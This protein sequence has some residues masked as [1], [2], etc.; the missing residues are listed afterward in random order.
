MS[1]PLAQF[2]VN[3]LVPEGRSEQ[4]RAYQLTDASVSPS[5]LI[6]IDDD[7]KEIEETI[8]PLALSAK[9]VDR[10][11]NICDV[12]LRTGRIFSMEPEAARYEQIVTFDQIRAGGLPLAACA[13]SNEYRHIKGGPLI[14]PKKGEAD[15]GGRPGATRLEETCEHMQA[16]IKERRARSRA[17]TEAEDAKLKTMKPEDALAMIEQMGE[18]FGQKLADQIGNMQS[19]KQARA[20]IRDG[21]VIKVDEKTE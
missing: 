9:F 10:D 21:K 7:G 14:K 12:P 2:I 8:C 6:S 19:A 13:F 5:R 3:Q 11:G 15:C 20:A 17:R 4:G 18:A 1:N 16:V